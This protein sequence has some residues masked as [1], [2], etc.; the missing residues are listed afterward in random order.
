MIPADDRGFT[1]GDGVFETVRAEAGRPWRWDAHMARL[2]GACAML[3][4]PAPEPEAVLAAAERALGDGA[5]EGQAAVRIS[6]SAGSGGRGLDR[7]ADLAPQLVAA[8]AAAPRPAGP[9]RLAWA[10]LRR[11]EH[12]PLSRCKSLAYLDNVLARAEARALGADEALLLNTA[13]QV[14]GAAAA[15]VFWVNEGRLFTPSLSCGVLNG[16]MR[17]EVLAAAHDLA[18][19]TFEVSAGPEAVDAAEAVFLTNVLIGVRPAGLN[20]PANAH[21]LI[22]RLSQA[23]SR[24]T[25]DTAPGRSGGVG[26]SRWR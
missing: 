19:E 4:L 7:P 21:P 23:L 24:R 13:G 3:G 15:N 12:S 1:L 8:A 11:N 14:S 9:A 18:L 10:S 16:V 26:D 22:E 6:W 17:G 2:S 25:P 5:I 20:R